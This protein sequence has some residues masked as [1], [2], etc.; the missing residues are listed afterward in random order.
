M[1]PAKM[2]AKIKFKR[3]LECLL[4]NLIIK[5]MNWKEHNKKEE[6]KNQTIDII[7]RCN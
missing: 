3:A 6:L 1:G 5:K 2:A 7:L 4:L